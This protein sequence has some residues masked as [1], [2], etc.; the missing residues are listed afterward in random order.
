MVARGD[1]GVEIPV[2]EVIFAQK[3]MIEKCVRARKVVITATQ[4]L[5]SMIK[6]P[7]PTRAEAGDVANAIIDG[8]DAVMLS[9][10]SAKG[11]YPLEAVTIM[12]TICERTD[13]VMTSRLD[14]NNDSRKM[15]ITEAVCRGA[16]ETAEKLD[17]PLIVVATQGGKSAKAVRKYFPSATILALTTN[18]TTARQ[19]VLSKGVIPH[20]VKEIAS[21]DDFYRLGKEVAL[22]LVDRGL[23]RKGDVVV[24]VSGALVPSGTTN[25]ASVHVL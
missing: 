12:A 10:E 3:M 19:L 22:Q 16:V 4:M 11:K 15:R 25:T 23:A 17:A 9:G 20:L 18:E 21:T 13:R 1:L 14:S 24:M 7:R 8:T 5:D 2:E 6:N